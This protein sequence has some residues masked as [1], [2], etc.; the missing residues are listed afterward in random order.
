MQ[1][2][3]E[4][5]RE[6]GEEEGRG[7]CK[8][9]LAWVTIASST[10]GYS[11]DSQYTSNSCNYECSTWTLSSP[12]S[13]SLSRSERGRKFYELHIHAQCERVCVC[14]CGMP[15]MACCMQHFACLNNKLWLPH[16]GSHRA[17]ASAGDWETERQW[18]GQ[19][20]KQTALLFAIQIMGRWALHRFQICYGMLQAEQQ[21]RARLHLRLPF[22]CGCLPLCYLTV[23]SF[24]RVLSH[25]HTERHIHTHTHIHFHMYVYSFA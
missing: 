1:D 10:L 18:D 13:L 6:E 3:G 25:T 11:R 21:R 23:S 2:R 4:C 12:L 24:P 17:R 15:G 7:G 20:E 16:K 19:T 22:V 14:A 9:D 8:V 5:W